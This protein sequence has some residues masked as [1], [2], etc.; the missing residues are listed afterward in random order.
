MAQPT[1][2]FNAPDET[3]SRQPNERRSRAEAVQRLSESVARFPAPDEH[4]AIETPGDAAEHIVPMFRTMLRGIVL[5]LLDAAQRPLVGLA[6]HDAPR[7][8][9]EPVVELL[10]SL[11]SER[12]HGV[13]L[14]VLSHEASLH[15]EPYVFGDKT[16]ATADRLAVDAATVHAWAE[17]SCRLEELG[18]VLLD[19]IECTPWSWA[20]VHAPAA[21]Y[22]GSDLRLGARRGR[23]GGVRQRANAAR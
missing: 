22:L 9:F 10:A 17:F 19:V 2:P 6:V 16:L 13:I 4:T 5:L 7:N 14:G 18:I 20:S 1:L 21:P 11:T 12:P 3:R 8:E 15:D 23:S